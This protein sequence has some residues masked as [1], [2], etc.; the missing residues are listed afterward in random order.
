MSLCICIM[1]FLNQDDYFLLAALN[2][3]R[4]IARA[5]VCESVWAH[6]VDRCSLIETTNLCGAM[7]KTLFAHIW[8]A[9]FIEVGG[10]R[11]SI[12]WIHKQKRYYIVERLASK[13][14][15]EI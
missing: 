6:V 3:T 8:Y 5:C 2:S 7:R 15:Y 11:L 13:I 14:S 1:Y 10:Y 4:V 9:E 12:L